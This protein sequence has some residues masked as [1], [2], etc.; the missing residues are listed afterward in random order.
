MRLK[1]V[2]TKVLVL[3]MLCTT[4][5]STAYAGKAYYTFE[6]KNTGQNITNRSASTNKKTIKSNPW[7]L[8]VTSIT[9]TGPNGIRFVPVKVRR[10]GNTVGY[11]PCKA[12]GVWRS[13]TGYGTTK[14]AK[15]D[16]ALTTY[17]LGARMDD[18]YHGTFRSS[19]WWNADRY[20]DK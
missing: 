13:G 11:T 18:D 8:K 14:Y 4:L 1:K 5:S 3:S 6:L 19:G 7:T 9:C 16:A 15:G 10:T 12:S 17:K 20:S 2:I